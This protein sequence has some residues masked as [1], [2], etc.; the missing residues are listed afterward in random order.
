MRYLVLLG[1]L[2]PPAFPRPGVK[3]I[4]E[5]ERVIVWDCTWTPGV[6]TPM[7]FHDKLHGIPVTLKE[8]SP[9]N[10]FAQCTADCDIKRSFLKLLMN[11]Y[12]GSRDA[13]N[14][15]NAV[16]FRNHEKYSL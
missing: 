8:L 16:G 13:Q 4:L 14:V 7:H 10:F 11:G 1:S 6:A 5:N 3:K 9:R 2:L 15:Y 12:D